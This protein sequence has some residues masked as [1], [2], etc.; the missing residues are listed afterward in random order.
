MIYNLRFG[1]LELG[2]IS[3]GAELR[4][5]GVDPS[6]DYSVLK[7]CWHVR[8][9]RID[10]KAMIQIRELICIAVIVARGT[11]HHFT[12]EEHGV[13]PRSILFGVSTVVAFPSHRICLSDSSV[14]CVNDI[15]SSS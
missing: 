7:D 3:L 2:E 5:R 13:T 10:Y 14:I 4:G 12:L 15:V 8:T 11:T 6:R 9:V 1:C